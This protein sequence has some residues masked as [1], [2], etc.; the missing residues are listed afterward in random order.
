MDGLTIRNVVRWLLGGNGLCH[1]PDGDVDGLVKRLTDEQA[2]RT[3]A[4]KADIERAETK[5]SPWRK[6][7][8]V[9]IPYMWSRNAAES[10]LRRTATARTAGVVISGKVT[11]RGSSMRVAVR[12]IDPPWGEEV[13]GN[14]RV[15]YVD[16]CGLRKRRDD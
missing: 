10:W 5:A 13:S 2:H 7:Q 1:I 16:L 4:R 3:K 12:A 15:V 11:M 9:T 14:R 6:G 8:K